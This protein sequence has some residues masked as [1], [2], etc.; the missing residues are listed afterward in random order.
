MTYAANKENLYKKINEIRWHHARIK[1]LY[2]SCLGKGGR[3]RRLK[4]EQIVK[5]RE[6]E[7]TTEKNFEEPKVKDG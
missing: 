2:V 3:R 1:V 4:V 5:K 7:R 6:V